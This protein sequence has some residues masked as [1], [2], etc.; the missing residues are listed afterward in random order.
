MVLLNIKLLAVHDSGVFQRI[1]LTSW[2]PDSV[3]VLQL[4]LQTVVSLFAYVAE[5]RLRQV[6]KKAIEIVEKYV[7]PFL[8]GQALSQFDNSPLSL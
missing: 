7:G 8:F 5:Q 6:C 4:L 2:W 3:F 1:N